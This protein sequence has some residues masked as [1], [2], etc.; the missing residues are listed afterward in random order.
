MKDVDVIDLFSEE[1]NKKEKKRNKKIEKQRLKEEKQ[2]LKEAKKLEKLEDK[3][4][5]EYMKKIKEEKLVEEPVKPEKREE[6]FNEIMSK[7]NEKKTIDEILAA[8]QDRK[9]DN[10]FENNKELVNKP[11]KNS[12]NI[13]DH[14]N[15][16][17]VEKKLDDDILKPEI[18]EN[19]YPILNFIL[20]IL[21]IVLLVLSLDYIFYNV[22]SN[23]KNLQ[24]MI[25]SILL[26]VMN[27]FYLLSILIDKKGIKKSFEILSILAMIAFM[28]YHLFIA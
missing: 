12:E 5:D 27:I 28:S 22:I 26:V 2:K 19:K 9:V 3:E 20:I 15:I 4:F 18:K 14:I 13:I 1:I 6:K 25:N 24:T 11:I 7:V 23:Y 16:K 10:L 17:S 21:S 8:E